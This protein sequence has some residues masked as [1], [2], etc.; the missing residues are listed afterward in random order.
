MT[1][2]TAA[3]RLVNGAVLPAPGSWDIDPGHADVAFTGRHLMVSRVRGRFTDVSGTVRIADHL[4]DSRVDVVIGMASVE[5]GNPAR[6]EHLRSNELFDVE[7]FPQA[8]FH[9]VRV[10]WEGT[11]GIA[12][13]DLTI[14]GV[15]REVPL[16]VSF[17]GHARDP[18]GGDRAIFSGETTINREEFGITWN[19]AL[20][21]GGMLVSKD[22]TIHIEIETVRSR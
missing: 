10:D 13:G 7:R 16:E 18:W 1:T 11:R 20:E 3:T 2:S 8:T 21:A 4:R 22:I 17:H 6:D 5:T 14:H 15:T 12:H 9:S 19:M